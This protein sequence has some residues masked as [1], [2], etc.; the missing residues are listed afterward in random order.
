[1]FGPYNGAMTPLSLRDRFVGPGGRARL[2]EVLA[3]QRVV[4]GDM[5]LAGRF[6]E[7]LE[8]CE[9]K[10]GATVIDQDGPDTDVQGPVAARQ[11]LGD[12]AFEPEC[13]A[14]CREGLS[15]PDGVVGHEP[16]PIA[17][18]LK[19]GQ[20]GAPLDI[21]QLQERLTVLAKKIEGDEGRRALAR[22]ARGEGPAPW[23]P[24]AANAR[25]RSTP[26]RAEGD[27]LAVEDD[28]RARKRARQLGKLGEHVGKVRPRGG[29]ARARPPRRPQRAPGSH[30]TWLQRPT[31]GRCPRD[32]LRRTPRASGAIF[33]TGARL[34]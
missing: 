34:A 27:E 17:L 10:P 8:V 26:R 9:L 7:K 3:R 20:P 11:L 29:C 15:L 33:R 23:S 19:G 24:A 30:P 16:V 6:A 25:E 18:E 21:R 13:L 4:G 5:A 28:L 22:Q 1:V 12:E 2:L 32:S 14:R 31:L